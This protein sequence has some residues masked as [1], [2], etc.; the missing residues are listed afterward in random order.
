M[1]DPFDPRVQRRNLLLGWALF[2]VFLLIFGGT[3]AAFRVAIV[4]C[5]ISIGPPGSAIDSESPATNGART[6]RFHSSSM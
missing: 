1:I 3:V 4:S 5:A 6:R 2:A